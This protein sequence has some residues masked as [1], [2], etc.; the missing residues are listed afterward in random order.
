MNRAETRFGESATS[1]SYVQVQTFCSPSKML[2]TDIPP[3]G[4]LDDE[5][6]ATLNGIH[7]HWEG[8]ISSAR[9]SK[10]HNPIN[11]IIHYLPVV[12]FIF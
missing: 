11:S 9:I 5:R 7:V 6:C 4:V 2:G 3:V 1:V 10:I 12:S 8:R